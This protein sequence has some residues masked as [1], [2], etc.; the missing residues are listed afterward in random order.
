MPFCGYQ[1]LSAGPLGGVGRE[2]ASRN[3]GKTGR[4]TVGGWDTDLGWASSSACWDA[5]GLGRGDV[6]EVDRMTFA[7][8]LDHVGHRVEL[9]VVLIGGD[10]WETKGI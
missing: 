8:V 9:G 4:K 10:I 3:C 7:L 5:D 6:N 2:C 1:Q